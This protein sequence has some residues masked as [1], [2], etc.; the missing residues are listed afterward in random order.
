M[1]CLW[2]CPQFRGVLI[3]GFLCTPC[4]ETLYVWCVVTPDLQEVWR[5]LLDHWKAPSPY[6]G[7]PQ[8]KRRREG[9][10]QKRQ[11][12]RRQQSSREDSLP[13]S[14]QRE[15][16]G[17]AVGRGSGVALGHDWAAVT[18]GDTKWVD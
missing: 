18:A 2:R 9:W 12:E 1:Y 11:E 15:G 17:G 14:S 8:K 3:E 10:K 16:R 6:P 5:W 13:V 4:V 7:E